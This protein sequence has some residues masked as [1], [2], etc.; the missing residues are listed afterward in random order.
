MEQRVHLS[1]AL[2]RARVDSK[3]NRGV[4]F[5]DRTTPRSQA[6]L[7]FCRSIRR[8]HTMSRSFLTTGDCASRAA[9]CSA[10]HKHLRR[11]AYLALAIGAIAAGPSASAQSASCEVTYTKAWEGGN[12]FGADIIITNL[13][14][15]ITNGWTLQFDFP[16]GQR[17][18]HGW[19]VSFSQPANSATVT[20]G[21]HAQWNESI[22][23]GG[24][25][26]VGFNGT[27]SGAN[28]SPT[29]F[30]LNGTVCNGDEAEN[31]APTIS[32][33]SPTSGQAFS[34]G[35][36][37]P[38]AATASDS[39]GEV[40]RVEFYVDGTLVATDSSAPFSFDASGLAA[41]DHTAQAS[42]YDNGSPSL[43]TSTEVSFTV[44]GGSSNL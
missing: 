40:V 8:T 22:A 5:R 30:T 16:D 7:F 34:E 24:S 14:P 18:Q 12:G 29:Q 41:G 11:A 42:A 15:A 26:N 37:V 31:A 1:H 44:Q 4:P 36:T 13:G 10:D 9:W 35:A 20:V 33:T 25:F 3:N 38:L 19:P 32:L 6:G 2:T 27:F 17:L 23:S 28:G 21:S 39:D 43:S